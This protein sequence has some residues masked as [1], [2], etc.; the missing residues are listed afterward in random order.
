MPKLRTGGD[1]VARLTSMM[2]VTSPLKMHHMIIMTTM[3]GR[4]RG[5]RAAQAAKSWPQTS[6]AVC[7]AM[8]SPQSL[9]S[10]IQAL[11]ARVSPDEG[12]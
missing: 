5:V 8:V 9:A 2:V 6:A 10:A 3:R 4:A 7:A 12:C 1:V 11:E